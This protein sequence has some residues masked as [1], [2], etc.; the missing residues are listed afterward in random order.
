MERFS[1]ME[2]KQSRALGLAGRNLPGGATGMTV[3]KET[4]QAYEKVPASA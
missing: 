2:F 4:R 3:R 1:E